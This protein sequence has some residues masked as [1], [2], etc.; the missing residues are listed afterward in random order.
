MTWQIDPA[1]S[2]VTFGVKHMLIATVRGQFTE[3]DVDAAIDEQRPEQSAATV[4]IAA[5]SVETGE[6]NRD[7][8]LRSADFFDAEH[9]PMIVFRSKRIEPRGK[10]EVRVVGDL[11]VKDVTREVVLEGEWSLPREDAFGEARA[12]ISVEGK[13]NRKDFG[14]NW[15]APVEMG[16]I[17]V[18]DTVKLAV[19]LE[20]VRRN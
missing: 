17:V 5:A 19:D 14:L 16:G 11:T 7:N 4:A 6:P 20:F 3:F 9:Y 12:G 13:V 18:G 1:H 8:H 15:S 2:A 10:E